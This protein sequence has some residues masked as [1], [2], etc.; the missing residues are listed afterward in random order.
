MD[1]VNYFEFFGLPE[2]LDVDEA[3]LK[4]RFYEQSKK[5]HPDFY[6]L[7]SPEKQAEILELSTINNEAWRT[8][9]NFDSRLKYL[10]E[11]KGQLG[12]EGT[13][14]LPQEFLMEMMDINEAAMELEFDFDPE[15]YAAL[16]DQLAEQERD[17]QAELTGSLVSGSA[18]TIQFAA[19][20][21]YHLKKRYLLRIKESLSKFAVPKG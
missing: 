11:L 15:R 18:E 4:R 7:E 3:A 5:F 20:K 16:L 9:S 8:L 1:E 12:E 19:M 14:V 13:N 10:L 2:S 21:D 17:L 6:T